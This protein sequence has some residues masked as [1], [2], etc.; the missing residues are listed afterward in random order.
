[1]LSG[2]GLVRSSAGASGSP[3][4]AQRIRTP[5]TTRKWGS[6]PVVVVILRASPEPR[7]LAPVKPLVDSL[8]QWA[9]QGLP[10]REAG[11]ARSGWRDAKDEPESASGSYKRPSRWCC[12]HRGDDRLAGSGGEAPAFRRGERRARRTP[13]GPLGGGAGSRASGE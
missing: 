5:S 10:G 3:P 13:A 7:R 11:A 4:S 2:Q 8:G 6:I 9:D 1:M 12:R